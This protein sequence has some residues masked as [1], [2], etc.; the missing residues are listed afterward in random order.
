MAGRVAVI[1]AGS[2]GVTAVKCLL[3]AGFTDVVCYER[4]DVIG[5][6]WYYKET[7]AQWKDESC[8][9]RATVINTS[10]EFMAFSDYPMPDYYPNFCHNADVEDYFQDYCRHF[11]VDKYIKFNSEVMYLKKHSSYQSTGKWEIRIKDHKTG[12]EILEVFDFVIVANGHHGTP[13]LP[14]FPGQESFQGVTMHSKDFKDVRSVKSSRAVVVGIGNSGG[15][16]AV[17]LSKYTKVFLS[18]RRGAWILNRLEANGLPWDFYYHSRLLRILLHLLPRSY[19]N[20]K[21]KAIL[22]QRFNHD[23]Y[24]LTPLHE[25]DATHPTVNDELPNR[26]AA[27]M[28]K[29]KPNIKSFSAKGVTFEDGTYEDD[30]DLVVFATGY[31]VEYPFIDKD[32]VQVRQNKVELYQYMWLPELPK[33]TIAFLAVCQPLGAM[34][35]I[36]EMQSRLAARVFKEEVK[37]PPPACM[38]KDICAKEK[39]MRR[40]YIDTQRHTIQVDWLPYMDELAT[41]VGC[42]PN[43]FKLLVTDPRLFW[44]VLTGPGVPYQFRL[45]G[46]NPWPGA[47]QAIFTVIDRIKKPFNTRPLPTKKTSKTKT[48]VLVSLGVALVG[49]AL[50]YVKERDIE[51]WKDWNIGVFT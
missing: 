10:K 46:P 36:A 11:G 13:N 30:I 42:K 24:H 38:K 4:R 16:I 40:R 14:T 44:R 25:P 6:L 22:N 1:G 17:E 8:V 34:F 20:S 35:P 32:V 5:G 15:D 3:E 51:L 43:L 47:R 48:I 18:T 31:N 49:A 29:V 21:R 23:L 28:V 50:L 37:L 33:Q 2:S 26:I 27:G 39:A 7:A 41:V 19:M 9:N 45:H 12:K